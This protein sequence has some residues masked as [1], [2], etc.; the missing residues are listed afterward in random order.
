M[1][2]IIHRN[3]LRMQDIPMN[4]HDKKT[5]TKIS[6]KPTPCILQLCGNL[7]LE[8]QEPILKGKEQ[9]DTHHSRLGRRAISKVPGN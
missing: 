6:G 7:F 8:I 3:T 2:A 5:I 4:K 9:T 1:G